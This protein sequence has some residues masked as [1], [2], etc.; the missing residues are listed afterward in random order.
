LSN[1]LVEITVNG[2]TQNW[3][4]S[5]GYEIPVSVVQ[6][7]CNKKGRRLKN[8]K[9]K[10]VARG[11][12]ITVARKDLPPHSNEVLNFKCETCGKSYTTTWQ[13]YRGKI[14][15]NCRSCQAKKGFKGGCH[16]YWVNVLIVN[17]PDAKC[18]ISGEA[19]KRF[20]VLHHLY[21]RD[22]KKELSR[23]AYVILS[24]NY[25]MAFH[26]WNGGTNVPCTPEK[27]YEFKERELRTIV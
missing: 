23:D 15:N 10:R 19:D 5:R 8:G 22:N 11:T 18:D 25:H 24:A 12:K 27:Y 20:L 17:S 2:Q 21:S 1:E 16:S 9:E 4:R 6:L 26:V 7:Y 14:S 3:Y 13:A